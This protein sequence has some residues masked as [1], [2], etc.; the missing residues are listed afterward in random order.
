VPILIDLPNDTGFLDNFDEMKR[1]AVSAM[2]N[3]TLIRGAE[4]I[5]IDTLCVPPVHTIDK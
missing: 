2:G 5:T 1:V 4:I 3:I